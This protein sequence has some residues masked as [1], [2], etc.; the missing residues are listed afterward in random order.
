MMVPSRGE[1]PPMPD[2]SSGVREPV[3]L[4]AEEF[5]A[6]RRRGE[7]PT[8]EEYAAQ[9][10]EL[11]AAIRDLFPALLLM[12]NLDAGSLGVPAA[13]VDRGAATRDEPGSEPRPAPDQLGDYRILRQIGRGGMGVVYEAEQ[14]SLGRRV[15]LKVL[16]V[17]ALPDPDQVRRF[18]REAKAAARLHH[19][20]IVPVFGVGRQDGHHYY[21]MQFIA[22]LGLD[23]VLQD[24]RRFRQA[25]AGS[26]PSVAD[27][28]EPP[29]RYEPPVR[30]A[31]RGRPGLT[32][33]EVARSLITGR[34]A[35]A[36]SAVV[37]ACTTEARDGWAE[38]TPPSV[39]PEK[40]APGH[41]SSV[42]LPG[43]SELSAVS[44]SD[45]RYFQSIARI[46]VQ[47]AEALE[48]ANRQGI[49]HRDI[50][51][52]NLLLDNQGNVWV[53]DFGLAK[54][55]EADDLTRTGDIL[56]TIRYMAP[57]RFESRCDARS[58]VYSL[59]LTLY[60]LVALRPA[61]QAAD[62]HTLIERVM[63][64]EP[65]RLKKWAPTVPRDLETIIAKATARDPVAR[66]PT[67]GALAE[68]LQRFVEDRPIRARRGPPTERL[69]RWC[70]R[71]PVV[72]GLAAGIALA[73]VLGTAVATAFAIQARRNAAEARGFARRVTE[74][75]RKATDEARRAD[76]E[77]RRAREEKRFSDHR[78]YDAE[79]IL[80]HQ[81]WQE[82]ATGLAQQYLQAHEPE[83]PGN[84][85]DLRGFEWYYLRRLCQPP[86][87]TLR[88]SSPVGC[89]AYSPD[90]RILASASEDGAVKLWD[91]A[92]GEEV[93]TLHGHGRGAIDSLAFRPDGHHVASASADGTVRLW[94]VATGE[95]LRISPLR[96][97]RAGVTSVAYSPDGRTLASAS[98]DGTMKLWDAATGRELRTLT[99]HA[100]VVWGVAYNPDGRTLASASQDQTVRVWDAA[101]GQV[102]RTLTG[103]LNAA[104]FV[105][106]SPDGRTLASASWD[107]TVRLWDAATGREVRTLIGHTG[108]LVFLAFSPD[109]ANLA[110]SGWDGTV[111]LWDVATGREIRTL[112]GHART[113]VNAG[114]Y[115]PDG[116]T[117]ASASYDG[118]VK[119]WDVATDQEALAL[120][121]HTYVVEGVAYSPD[122][123]TLASA[124]A[125][126]TVRLW[127]AATGQVLHTLRG[128]TDH[129]RRVAYSPDGRTL[130]SASSDQTVRLWDVTTGQV[131]RTLRGHTDHVVGM[132]Y[133]PDG[134]NLASSGCDGTVRLWDVATG[135]EIR[136]LRGHAR[137]QVNAAHDAGVAV[138]YS[139]DG[140]TLASASLDATVK[141]WDVHT[142]QEIR[143]LPDGTG[144]LAY[145]PDG[146]TL[147][148]AGS[149]GLLRLWVI[150]TGREV[151]TLRGH[152]GRVWGAAF[153]PD[154]RR[155][156]SS[157]ADYALKLWD[158]TTGQEVLTLHGHSALSGC[159]AFSPDGRMLASAS[160][161]YSV[162]LWDAR[163]L[164]PELQ[165]LREARDLVEFHFAK[166][167]PTAEVL[168]RIRHDGT[169]SKPVRRRALEL[170]EP[171]GHNLV[172]H[173]ADRL[174]ES[175]YS[176][177]MFRSEVLASLRADPA[178]RQPVRQEAL[179]LAEQ[180]PENPGSLSSASW[181]A[182]RQPGAEP[183]AYRLA[184][185]Q[186]ETACRLVP[187]NGTYL[188]TLGMAE[189]R[190]GK[191]REAVAALERA[192]RI[193]K[194]LQESPDPP[195]LAFLALA[196]HRLG[197][198]DQARAVLSRLRELMKKAERARDE[199]AQAFLREAEALE[200]DLV[201]PADPFAR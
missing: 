201:L 18:E 20:N 158:V 95:G 166:S 134:A 62:R 168:D 15:A 35:G 185:R 125:D 163:P 28:L 33:A 178:L 135:R 70:R 102:L 184:L 94:D 119:L 169:I 9:H 111:R 38:A 165:V 112:R 115:S 140:R 87:R 57:E 69:V 189:Y 148:S 181:N 139:P 124:G 132:A 116:R 71:N 194:D 100:G 167:L 92:T 86:L 152:G 90:G 43:S 153:S 81:A 162:R 174:V 66:Y 24:L 172:V 93:R 34:F 197:Q 156:A 103:H 56:G 110:S 183:A 173:E 161:D 145:S 11:A 27:E 68:D 198:T 106:F 53:A 146:R 85:E 160:L 83:R 121:G 72:A 136:C 150:A 176:K 31:A 14:E 164:T 96:G 8:V 46:G 97:H 47:V 188:T 141:L 78:L 41:S 109:G 1:M 44:D 104:R 37:C 16:F 151:R 122:G 120:R 191:D 127:D 45:R 74:E 5:L 105:A 187:D 39:V 51:P 7:R 79:M 177:P 3:E 175:L 88:H 138:A 131:L 59:G 143:T 98:H 49:L 26:Q 137:T 55:A 192:D 6:R 126:R 2:S 199:P 54:T 155:L 91:A 12:D 149:E 107:Q 129:V 142:G 65:P 154:G 76:L 48:Y 114:A 200:L 19:T 182:V 196:H 113:E 58:D 171:Y 29:N 82:G 159:V 195:D 128:H 80:A 23:L 4:L 10:P 180:I 84:P 67:A 77:A 186:A 101:T 130:A 99:G 30:L 52:S 89:V 42:V 60:E 123:R 13:R 40:R 36:G 108:P 144:P 190:V 193:K 61:Y 179:A 118:T 157:S 32:A 117:L 75:A 170:A 50:K 21:V 22:G 73:L 133:S 63:H 147:A 25:K 64:E 17:G